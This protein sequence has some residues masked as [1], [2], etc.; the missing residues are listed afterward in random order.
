MKLDFVAARNAVP[1]LCLIHE[2]SKMKKTIKIKIPTQAPRNPV[3]VPARQ[4]RAGPMKDGRSSK[5]GTV[6]SQ[7]ELLEQWKEDAEQD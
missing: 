1:K 2:N 5:G 4:R 7:R 6:N 3:V